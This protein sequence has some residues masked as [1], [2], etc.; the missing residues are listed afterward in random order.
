VE[1]DTL[2]HWLSL[3]QHH[4]LPTRLLDWSYSPLV[5]L[6]FATARLDEL[7]RDGCVWMV[8]YA[9]AHA[10]LPERL[11]R[12]LER[13]R[14]DV[15][16]VEMLFD[17]AETLAALSDLQPEPFLLFFEPPA[18]SERIANQYALFSMLSQRRHRRRLERETPVEDAKILVP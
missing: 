11:R 7:D 6:H 4:G 3:A 5:A 2:W 10:D 9:E 1:A 16:T 15:F 12:A 8:R 17:C 18:L 14:C 13:E